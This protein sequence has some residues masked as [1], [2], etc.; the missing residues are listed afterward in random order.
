M[1]LR[2]TTLG[3]FVCFPLPPNKIIFTAVAFILQV[4]LTTV[5]VILQVRR[6][7]YSSN[8]QFRNAWFQESLV[9]NGKKRW[10]KSFG[11]F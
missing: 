1:C 6:D 7:M 11:K 10:Q 9:F 4:L 2:P 8:L 3:V 5:V